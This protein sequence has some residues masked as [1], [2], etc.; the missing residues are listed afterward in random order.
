[1]VNK[2]EDICFS[3]WCNSRTWQTDRLTDIDGRTS[4]DGNTVTCPHTRLAYHGSHARDLRTTDAISLC[5]F[6]SWV[7][8]DLGY[9]MT[10]VRIDCRYEL[11]WVWVDRGYEITWVRVDLVRVDC[12]PM[13]LCTISTFTS[14]N[15]LHKI[16]AGSP[17]VGALNRAGVWQC[18]AFWP[19][20]CYISEMVEDRWVNA[21]KCSTSIE[22][23][24]QTCDIYR[25][26]L[27]LM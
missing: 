2:F 4:H 5:F 17:P 27:R 10:W 24:F 20:T 13:H 15:H 8:V 3:F 14:I 7:R 16:L 22:S 23:F 11:T 6:C 9:D 25:N 26:S 18:R 12:K 21:V 1:M 19:I